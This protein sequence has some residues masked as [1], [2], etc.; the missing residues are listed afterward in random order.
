M[1]AFILLIFGWV[2]VALAALGAALPL[3]P[4]TPFLLLAAWCFARSSPR[5]H[6]WL[7]YRSWFA[8]YLQAWQR[9]RAMPKGAKFRAICVIVLSFSVS[10]IL[11]P[12]V[13]LRLLLL[14]VFVNNG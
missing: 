8:R 12:S 3:L 14:M 6:R 7:L 13:W 10:I 4:A 5:F 11:L 2:A 9:H 1:P